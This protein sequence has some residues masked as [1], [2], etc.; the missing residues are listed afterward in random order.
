MNIYYISGLGADERAFSKLDFVKKHSAKYIPWLLPIDKNE[1]IENYAKRMAEFIKEPNPI[2]IGLSFGGMIAMEI[3]KIIPIEKVILISS[4][5]TK[6][7][8][9][10]QIKLAG[11]LGLDSIAPTA[12]IKKSKGIMHTFLGTKS[13]E[14]KQIADEFIDKIDE[15][16]LAWSMKNI[17][18]WK[19]SEI[20]TKTIHIHGNND[21]L[22]QSKFVKAD[23]IIEDG[24]HFMI[25]NKAK[26]INP[27]LNK[28][29]D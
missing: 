13:E 24:N 26:M 5:K 1:R 14:E 12:L 21:A 6:K 11:T 4:C 7:E 10:T 28:I 27:I 9:P 16:Y 22:L 8:L 3:A 23:Y 19:N 17:S 2:I 25:Y 15:G 18:R 20:A 29:L